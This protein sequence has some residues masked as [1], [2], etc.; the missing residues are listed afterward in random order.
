MRLSD[1]RVINR[2]KDVLTF[3]RGALGGLPLASLQLGYEVDRFLSRANVPG[4][5]WADYG[6]LVVAGSQHAKGLW[7]AGLQTAVTATHI[8]MNAT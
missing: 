4:H 7:G 2:F 8:R 5:F 3:V 6:E 1:P